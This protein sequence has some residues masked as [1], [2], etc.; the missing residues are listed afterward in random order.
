MMGQGATLTELAAALDAAGVGVFLY[1]GSKQSERWIAGGDRYGG[2]SGGGAG[3][4]APAR[5]AAMAEAS[6]GGAV[7]VDRPDGL[8][9]RLVRL[10]DGPGGAPRFLGVLR[11][12]E[13][14]LSPPPARGEGRS[15]FQAHLT[16]L[17]ETLP[18][19]TPVTIC[20]VGVDGMREFCRAYGYD[21]GEAL[22]A[23][24]AAR[25]TR[26]LPPDAALARIG[27]AKFLAALVGEDVAAFRARAEA[28]CAEMSGASF[29][30]GFGPV[31]ITVSVGA[32]LARAD[33]VAAPEPLDAALA[34]LDEARAEGDG[35]LYFAD[36]TAT[37]PQPSPAEMRAGARAVMRAL[38]CDRVAIAFQPVVSAAEPAR[39]AFRECLARVRDD[40][41]NWLAAGSFL[42]KIERLDLVRSLDRRVLRL[43]LGALRDHPTE[44]LS[45]NVST[46]TMRDRTWIRELCAA[47]EQTPGVVERLI[48]ELTESAAVTDAARTKAFLDEVR[49]LGVAIALDD[50]GAGYSS[51]RHVRDFRPDWVKIDGGFVRGL[52]ADPDNKLFVDTLVGIARN[53]DMATVAEFVETD[54][55]AAALRELGV[56]CL[57][58]YRYGRPVIEPDWAAAAAAAVAV[59]GG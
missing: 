18:P 51:F 3:A 16:H 15:G 27:G 14:A 12:A 17:S 25:L 57:Q 53:F 29:D 10:A 50:F 40:D 42:P 39:V 45:I 24:A 9:E 49:A 20:T 19:A 52:H 13:A 55:D 28:L 22:A 34:A 33:A 41:G 58:G 11:A 7:D 48:V 26:A 37:G 31:S 23:A 43:A 46:R 2:G 5:A 38:E 56:D 30:V 36:A 32:A 47:A 6:A 4:S 21:A 8:G 44:R 35:S 1:D 54:A 59:A